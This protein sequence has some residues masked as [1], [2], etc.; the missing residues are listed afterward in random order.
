MILTAVLQ[1]VRPLIAIGGWTGSRYFSTAVAN[2][3]G[4]KAF[5][6]TV[7]NFVKKYNLDGV[8][9]ECVFFNP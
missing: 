4:R 6:K 9:F 3:Q 8:D 7:V 2:A 5:A 1:N